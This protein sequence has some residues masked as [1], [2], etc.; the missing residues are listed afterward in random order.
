[1]NEFPMYTINQCDIFKY[2]AGFGGRF[3]CV[4]P[5]QDCLDIKDLKNYFLEYNY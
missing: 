1:M 4:R 2:Q 3:S 5:T